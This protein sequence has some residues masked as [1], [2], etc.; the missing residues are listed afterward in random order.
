LIQ[1]KWLIRIRYKRSTPRRLAFVGL[2]GA[3]LFG[4][5]SW[6][7]GNGAQF[8]LAI[9]GGAAF[10]IALDLYVGWGFDLWKQ[11]RAI[12]DDKLVD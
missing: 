2:E 12:I 7:F 9:F 8:G 1:R 6:F 11:L 10:C 5:A 4:A 3:V